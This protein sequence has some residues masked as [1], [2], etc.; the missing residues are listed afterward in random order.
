[1]QDK[2]PAIRAVILTLVLGVVLA[3]GLAEVYDVAALLTGDGRLGAVTVNTGL[4]A[5]PV[6]LWWRQR[7]GPATAGGLWPWLPALTVFGA[8]VG[9]AL[10]S[11]GGQPTGALPGPRALIWILWVPVV[12]E[13]VFR[14]GFG[15]W[16]R[17]RLG[18]I[19]GCWTSA[20]FFSLMHSLPVRDRIL[21]GAAGFLPGPF[22][23][24]LAC[25]VILV[26]SGRLLPAIALHMVCNLSGP[27]FGYL[28]PRWLEWLGYLYL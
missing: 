23:L 16:F 17:R 6:F 24:G 9:A 25:E 7:S 14:A 8:V 5:L 22:L 10:I 4:A 26:R 2:P 15:L 11:S 27:L 18:V 19:A 20:L 3:V 21:S 1:M 13:W 28:D 12:E